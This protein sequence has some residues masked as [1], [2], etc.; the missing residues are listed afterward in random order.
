MHDYF[1]YFPQKSHKITLI[2]SQLELLKLLAGGL[3]LKEIAEK[4]GKKLNNI[5][6]RVQLLYEKLDVNN[7]HDLITIALKNNF[8]SHKNVTNRF[9]KR[10][11]KIKI[12][13]K[14]IKNVELSEREIK[15]LKLKSQ[16]LSQAELIE[17]LGLW[18]Y[19]GL[20]QLQFYV[21]KKMECKNI[22]EAVFIAKRLEII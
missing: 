6:K 19:Y 10:F 9:R 14:T 18:S 3:T 13:N 17:E 21:C 22:L 4:T 5:K 16:C 20:K 15:L 2:K 8:I 12:Q 1:Y 11:S 7:R